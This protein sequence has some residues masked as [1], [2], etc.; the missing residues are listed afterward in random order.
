LPHVVSPMPFQTPT[1]GLHVD[2]GLHEKP[3]Y[4]TKR[5]AARAAAGRMRERVRVCVREREREREEGKTGREEE[6]ERK[7]RE[8]KRDL[9]TFWLS[10]L[11]QLFCMTNDENG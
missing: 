1:Q 11:S 10:R 6:K 2:S 9:K 3:L 7:K 5:R 4:R 8:R